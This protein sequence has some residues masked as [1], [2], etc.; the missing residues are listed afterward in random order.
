MSRSQKKKPF[1][2]GIYA[3]SQNARS[4]GAVIRGRC[5]QSKQRNYPRQQQFT[6]GAV[7]RHFSGT[8]IHQYT[9]RRLSLQSSVNIQRGASGL[10]KFRS[11]KRY[12]AACCRRKKRWLSRQKRSYRPSSRRNYWRRGPSC[13][14]IFG[15]SY[16]PGYGLTYGPMSR[17]FR[18]R[19]FTR[20]HT[21]FRTKGTSRRVNIS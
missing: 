20:E 3:Q 4:T 14:I 2:Y 11:G 1:H 13:S 17:T 12:R 16:R 5:L 9:G 8:H 7:S 6:P 15:K 21:V 18:S 10:Q 19:S